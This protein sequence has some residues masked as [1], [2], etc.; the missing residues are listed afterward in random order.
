MLDGM[1]SSEELVDIVEYDC[2]WYRLAIGG[3]VGEDGSSIFSLTFFSVGRRRE[4]PRGADV[5]L[6]GC[7][8]HVSV[9]NPSTARWVPG[10][11]IGAQSKTASKRV[12]RSDGRSSG[13]L[14]AENWRQPGRR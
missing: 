10:H 7:R 8:Q 13:R 6:F 9:I 11:G 4:E 5:G 14:F 2:V 1:S 12:R 3:G